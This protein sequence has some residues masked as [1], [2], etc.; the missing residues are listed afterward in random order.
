[1]LSIVK[2]IAFKNLMRFAE[3][4]RNIESCWQ[5]T[6]DDDDESMELQHR[7]ENESYEKF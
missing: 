4:L 7:L 1:M 6:F 2:I 3:N 5:I